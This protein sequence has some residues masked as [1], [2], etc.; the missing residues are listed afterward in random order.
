MNLK[1]V[2]IVDAGI[3]RNQNSTEIYKKGENL[4]VYIKSNMTKGYLVNCVWPGESVFVDYNHPN[5]SKFWGECL[6]LLFQQLNF[7][8]I[9]IDMNEFSASLYGE[10]NVTENCSSKR[11]TGL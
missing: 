3:K 11:T 2:P 9:W 6:D 5:S 10:M 8:G 1:W 7:S 4:D